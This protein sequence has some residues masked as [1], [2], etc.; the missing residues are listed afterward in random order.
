MGFLWSFLLKE[1]LINCRFNFNGREWNLNI[2]RIFYEIYILIM[3][4]YK[5]VGKWL[6]KRCFI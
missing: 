6:M 1:I 2:C 5:N 3:F 4:K